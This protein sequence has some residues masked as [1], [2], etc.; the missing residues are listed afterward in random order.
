MVK[1]TEVSREFRFKRSNICW[2]LLTFLRLYLMNF[3]REKDLYKLFVTFPASLSY[4]IFVFNYYREII[5]A[6]YE[7]YPLEVI[8]ELEGDLQPPEL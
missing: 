8:E 1:D 5:L 6:L 2:R 4:E 7:R 3:Y